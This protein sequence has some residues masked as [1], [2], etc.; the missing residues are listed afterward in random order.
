MGEVAG[1]VWLSA[2]WPPQDGGGENA[3]VHAWRLRGAGLWPS[4]GRNPCLGP[5]H[6]PEVCPLLWAGDAK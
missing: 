3:Q 4:E 6:T 1:G 5:G 2:G